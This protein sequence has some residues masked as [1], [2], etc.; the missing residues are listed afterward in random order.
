MRHRAPSLSAV[1]RR[2]ASASAFCV[3]KLES[4]EL[5][6]S[7]MTLVPRCPHCTILARR[8]G[9]IQNFRERSFHAQSGWNRFAD[10]N[11]GGDRAGD[12]G[13]AGAA[14]RRR[15]VGAS[16]GKALH[17]VA[18]L[19]GR[20]AFLAILRA[21][22]DQQEERGEAP[23]GLELSHHRQQHLQSRRRRRRDVRPGRGRRARRDRCGDRQGDLAQGR[24]GALGRARD[25]LLGESRSIRPPVHLPA[26]RRRHRRE[27]AGR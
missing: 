21:R 17:D 24:R 8:N 3:S 6:P 11:R 7:A 23:G 19:R 9:A 4:A 10:G 27:R 22:S 25:E 13:R 5:A 15:A 16:C 1:S 12:A 18:V 20:C 26:A 2:P 14:G